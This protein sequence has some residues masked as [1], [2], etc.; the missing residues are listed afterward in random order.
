MNPKQLLA[1]LQTL[2]GEA[3]RKEVGVGETVTD[4]Q[5]LEAMHLARIQH[6]DI[7]RK[8]KRNSQRWMYRKLH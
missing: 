4:D 7:D 8:L 6:P 2:D 1:I 5:I 3:F